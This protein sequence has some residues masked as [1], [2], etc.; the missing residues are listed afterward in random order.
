MAPV[1]VAFASGGDDR[2]PVTVSQ[3]NRWAHV[4][5][6]WSDLHCPYEKAYAMLRQAEAM[7]ITRGRR[8]LADQLLQD[9]ADMTGHLGA[10]GLAGEIR[11]LRQM[12]EGSSR[13]GHASGLTRRELEILEL[14]ERGCSNKQIGQTLFISEKTA[15]VHVSNI[16]RKLGVSSRLEAAAVARLRTTGQSRSHS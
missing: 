13:E 10:E 11:G 5:E 15:S 2:S 9:A 8:H 12:S 6:L 16:L 1:S 4:V 7:L 3:P 14:L